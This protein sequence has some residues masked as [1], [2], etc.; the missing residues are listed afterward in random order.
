[1]IKD[2]VTFTNNFHNSSV[3]LR[4]D[5]DYWV[6]TARQVRRARE[7]LCGLRDCTCGGM[8]GERGPQS[9]NG[10]RLYGEWSSNGEVELFI[11]MD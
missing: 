4:L 9:W 2:T 8:L 11:E 7:A 5:E 3:N 6:L 10:R 1:M